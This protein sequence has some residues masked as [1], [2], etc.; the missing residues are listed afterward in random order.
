VLPIPWGAG[1]LLGVG[2]FALWA[3]YVW[4]FARVGRGTLASWNPTARRVVVLYRH[5]ATQ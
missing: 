5:A 4:H 2:G 3:W 1:V